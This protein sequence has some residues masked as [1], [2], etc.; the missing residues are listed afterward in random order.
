MS[1]LRR[2]PSAAT[3]EFESWAPDDT[4]APDP[5]AAAVPAIAK[6][7]GVRTSQ[8]QLEAAVEALNAAAARRG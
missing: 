3:Q 4:V 6:P 8:E 5:S 7:G 1:L 2:K